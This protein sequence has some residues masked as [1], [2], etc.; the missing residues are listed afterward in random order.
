[1]G[2]IPHVFRFGARPKKVG[3][4]V[5]R[6]PKMVDASCFYKRC[7][8]DCLRS[9]VGWADRDIWKARIDTPDLEQA[10]KGR[11]VGFFPKDRLPWQPN[12]NEKGFVERSQSV[13]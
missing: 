6:L 8:H 7:I 11:S 2:I 3:D 9:E 10:A 13:A 1:M 4:P 5:W 12:E